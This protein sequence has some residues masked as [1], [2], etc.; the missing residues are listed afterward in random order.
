MIP[1]QIT[2]TIKLNIIKTQLAQFT[3][4]TIYHRST[5][6]T[7]NRTSVECDDGKDAAKARLDFQVV[8]MDSRGARGR[9][10][11]IASA[12]GQST[13]HTPAEGL[14]LS[15]GVFTRMR[16]LMRPCCTVLRDACVIILLWSCK[17]LLSCCYFILKLMPMNSAWTLLI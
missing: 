17:S 14:M 2:I 16:C 12:S 3:A 15:S 4:A 8:S 6:H 9:R 11:C 5:K 13:Q 10:N 1:F 7:H